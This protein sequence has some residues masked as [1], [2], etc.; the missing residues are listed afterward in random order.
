ME[1]MPEEL[2]EEIVLR[3]PPNEPAY[4]VRAALVCRPWRRILSDRV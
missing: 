2:V 1:L 3:V 4:L